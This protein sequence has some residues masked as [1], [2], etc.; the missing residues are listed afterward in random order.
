[1]SKAVGVDV[2]YEALESAAE[3][4]ERNGIIDGVDWVHGRSVIPGMDE[5][6][7]VV[8]NILVSSSRPARHRRA[9]DSRRM[10]ATSMVALGTKIGGA[11]CLS[12]VRPDQCAVLE[13]LYAP[14][15]AC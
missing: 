5:Y 10:V 14:Y 4:A 1:M 11:L 2:E 6:D 3:N 9:S 13:R 7:A 15:Y 12:G 8:A